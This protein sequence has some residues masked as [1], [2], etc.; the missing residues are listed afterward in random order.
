MDVLDPGALV[1]FGLPIGLVAGGLLLGLLIE[2]VLLRWLRRLAERTRW[3]GDEIIITALKGIPIFWGA[4]AGLFIATTLVV[5]DEA[6]RRYFNTA[7]EVAI[8]WS[9]VIILARVA[10]GFTASYASRHSSFLPSTS[11]IANLVRLFVYVGGIMAVLYELNVAILPLL[12][13]LGLGG[14]AIALALQD[15]LSNV[16]AGLYLIAAR[17]IRPGDY[18]RLESGEEGYVTDINW[19]TT[20]VRTILHNL[21]IVP[22]SKLASSIVT[23]YHLPSRAMQ[24]VLNVGVAYGSDLDRVEAVTIEEAEAVIRETT[25]KPPATPP[26]M[27]LHTFGE[28]SLNFIVL[29]NVPEFYDQYLVRHRLI[30]RLL[31]RYAQEG[32]TIPFPIREF[33]MQVSTGGLSAAEPPGLTAA[34]A[35]DSPLHTGDPFAPGRAPDDLPR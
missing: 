11:I 25:G 35:D 15:T 19:R 31:R 23:N 2:R 26:L 20:S 24:I 13:P 12:A 16:F 17:Q 14:L 18:L 5:M 34:D 22:N 29:L 6:V 8:L 33:E 28:F 21:I 3:P 32:I 27:R 1:R 9:V 7:M 4:A 30:K 10:A